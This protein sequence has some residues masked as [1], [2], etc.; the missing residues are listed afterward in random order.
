MLINTVVMSSPARVLKMPWNSC[1]ACSTDAVVV[2]TVLLPTSVVL[3]AGS[4]NDL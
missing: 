4:Q 2:F 1:S 3:A